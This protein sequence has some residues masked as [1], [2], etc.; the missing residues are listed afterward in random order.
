MIIDY[1]KLK[2]ERERFIEAH[3][4]SIISNKLHIDINGIDE[5]SVQNKIINFIF[6]KPKLDLT[7]LDEQDDIDDNE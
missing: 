4:L 6:N 2:L 5:K 7:D 3:N 1:D